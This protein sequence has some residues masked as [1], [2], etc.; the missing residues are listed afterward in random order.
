MIGILYL[1]L[2]GLIALNVPDS[3]LDAFKNIKVSLDTSTGNVTKG[4][5]S[6]YTTFEATKLK[7][8]HDRAQPIYEKAKK[9][10]AVAKALNDYVQA[11]RDQL[12][13][14]GGGINPTIN[15]VS[16]RDNLDIS[17]HIMITNKKGEELRKK[18]VETRTK[19]L[20]FLNPKDRAGVNFSLNADDPKQAGGSG[21]SKNWE[22]AYFGDGIPLGATLTTLAKIQA[23]TKNAENEVVKKNIRPGRPGTG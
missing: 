2:L 14:E 8:Q 10:S 3:L 11:L 22:E 21:P 4:I 19:L 18:I 20:A 1:V 12:V 6:T 7:E 15:D 16:A 17:P 5:N 13:K 9:A 23:D